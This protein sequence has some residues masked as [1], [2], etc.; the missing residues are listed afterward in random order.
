MHSIG[1]KE[2]K[3][4]LRKD[5]ESRPIKEPLAEIIR[6]G[7]STAGKRHEEVFTRYFLCPS[8]KKFFYESVREGLNIRD[9]AISNGLGTEGYRNCAGFGFTPASKRKQLFTK[10]E[11]IK[12]QP[13]KTWMQA[14]NKALPPFQACPD[15]AIRNP[16]PL[17]IVGEVKYFKSGPPERAVRELY[18]AARQVVFY[19]AAF[20]GDYRSALIVV[21]DASPDHAFSKGLQLL[22]PGLRD[23]F[24]AD[25]DIHLVT[26]NLV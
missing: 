3:D 14:E 7:H 5:L 10:E 8:I 20:H 2:F 19:L 22:K 11:I 15:F 12:A 1:I 6:S 25:T 18:Q 9:D 26:I 21:A 23:R 17:S 24:G 4:Y 16:L 13:P